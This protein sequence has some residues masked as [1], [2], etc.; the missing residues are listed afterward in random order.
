MLATQPTANTANTVN[1]ARPE[2]TFITQQ[3]G[4]I[5]HRADFGA[6]E[7]ELRDQR[8]TL[9]STLLL[10]KQAEMALVQGALESKRTEFALRMAQCRTQQ[11]GL[12]TKQRM[13]C[14]RVVKFERFL[15]ETDGKKQRADTKAV[16]ERKVAAAKDH[17]CRRLREQA[18]DEQLNSDLVVRLIAKHHVFETY[19]QSIVDIVPPE[20]LDSAEPRI[21]DLILRHS[22][23]IETNTDLLANVKLNQ[24]HIET[25]RNELTTVMEDR[26]NSILVFNQK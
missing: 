25:S 17:E 10:R 1:T 11:D 15:R 26:S 19:L 2:G 12:R 22:T 6:I 18:Q 3:G 24:D 16:A 4:R 8:K 20:Y 5:V 9:Q 14:D 21:K 13:V 7:S 23:L